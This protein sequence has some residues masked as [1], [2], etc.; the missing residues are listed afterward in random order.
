MC[1][2]VKKPIGVDL[3]CYKGV[4]LLLIICTKQ[5]QQREGGGGGGGNRWQ[6]EAKGETPPTYKYIH[7]VHMSS[8]TTNANMLQR[9]SY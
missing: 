1:L 7:K 5:E 4:D 8:K 6:W 9:Y 2:A 3:L